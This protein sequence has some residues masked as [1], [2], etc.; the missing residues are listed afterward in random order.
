MLEDMKMEFESRG[1]RFERRFAVKESRNVY[2]RRAEMR[3]P[4]SFSEVVE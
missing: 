1:T 3:E 2:C 4:L